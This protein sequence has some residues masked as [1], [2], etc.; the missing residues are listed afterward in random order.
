LNCTPGRALTITA[1]ANPWPPFIDPQNQEEGLSMAI[2]RAAYKKSGFKVKL[3]YMPW[4]RAE[5]WVKSGK[6]DILPDTWLSE[7]RKAY[8]LYS[9]P[10][11]TNRIKFIKKK[12]DK[13]KFHG[14]NS[15]EGKKIGT[16]RGYQY[17]NEFMNS[18]LF[19]REETS[20]FIQNIRKLIHRRLDLV[21]ADEIVAKVYITK[22][23]PSLLNYIDF[24]EKAL[25]EKKLYVTCGKK[26]KNSKTIIE[27]FNNG[28]KFIK[29][30]GTYGKIMGK[31]QILH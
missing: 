13:F 26:N 16:I 2:I 3:I 10:Y 21:I 11:A 8:L 7:K 18:N 17:D 12:G 14:L 30:N 1:V 15:L 19:V 28:L 6:F 24:T 9:N 4:S 5:I 29:E 27:S 22:K 25:A 20:S 23:Y 31:Y